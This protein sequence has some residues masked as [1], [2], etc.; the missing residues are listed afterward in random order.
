MR[1]KYVL[2][3]SNNSKQSVYSP[4]PYKGFIYFNEVVQRTTKQVIT[5]GPSKISDVEAETDTVHDRDGSI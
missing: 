5:V 3:L 2:A 4:S 1:E